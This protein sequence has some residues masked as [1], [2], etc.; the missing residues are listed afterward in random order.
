MKKI[1]LVALMLYAICALQAQAQEK[2]IRSEYGLTLY[3]L[4]RTVIDI[5]VFPNPAAT[6]IRFKSAQ[7]VV[8]YKVEILDKK[9][10]SCIKLEHWDAEDL[11][12]SKLQAGTYIV[13]FTR[14]REE[15]SRK[16][17]VQR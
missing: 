8:G 7:P 5:T 14:G 11:D 6:N 16:L 4:K 12:I 1:S 15:C 2:V 13:R 10:R 17:V 3:P 9:G